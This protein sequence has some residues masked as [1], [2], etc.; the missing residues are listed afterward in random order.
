MRNCGPGRKE[1]GIVAIV[2]GAADCV[3]Q[4]RAALVIA[5]PQS[6]VGHGRQGRH[7]DARSVSLV[8]DDTLELDAVEA[9]Q[10]S[11]RADP[12]ESVGGLRERP[13]LAVQAVA[14]GPGRVM[15]LRERWRRLLRD[16]RRRHE[17]VRG[18][19]GDQTQDAAHDVHAPRPIRPAAG[20]A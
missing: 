16:D 3:E 14:G 7:G 19:R 5:D 8:C 6:A 17:H 18:T 12:Q 9:E 2:R 15:P 10:P 11:G 1:A 13:R 4:R 20:H